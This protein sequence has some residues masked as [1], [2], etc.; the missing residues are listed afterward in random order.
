MIQFYIID[1]AS[2]PDMREGMRN[3]L[4]SLLPILLSLVGLI[5]PKFKCHHKIQYPF[6][7]QAREGYSHGQKWYPGCQ[8]IL[9]LSLG[10]VGLVTERHRAVPKWALLRKN[11]GTV[12]FSC[13]NPMARFRPGTHSRIKSAMC[14][15]PRL[16][17]LMYL[18]ALF[19]SA[20]HFS[21]KMN[22]WQ[23]TNNN[24]C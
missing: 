6:Q 9:D 2:E 4:G 15:S 20:L 17:C 14:E 7:S 13:N 24:N 1:N 19:I 11:E 5:C 3:S 21:Y 23:Q 18:V 8:T 10:I 22:S 16:L 12:S